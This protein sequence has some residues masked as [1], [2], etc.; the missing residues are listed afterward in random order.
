MID[1]LIK[2]VETLED[3]IKDL[4]KEMENKKNNLL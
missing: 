3:E 4:R 2:K 1:I